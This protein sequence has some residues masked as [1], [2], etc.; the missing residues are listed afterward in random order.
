LLIAVRLLAGCTF[1]GMDNPALRDSIDWGPRQEI[2]TCVYLD[3]TVSKQ[4]ADKLL[5]SWND[6]EGNW[7]KLG[8]HPVSYESLKRDGNEFFYFQIASKL[9][10]VQRP[11]RCTVQIWFVARNL[12]DLV[13]GGAANVLG[14]PEVFGWTDDDTRTKAW[15]YANMVPDLNQLVMPP[16]AVTRHEIYHL[17]GCNHFDLAMSG[18]YQSI[19]NFKN[20]ELDATSEARISSAL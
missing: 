18:C 16:D 12:S 19:R 13:Y 14:L 11:D 3:E 17:L 4:N 10:A 6:R 1:I 5:G 2:P 8:I 20:R 9:Q 15:A 7:Y